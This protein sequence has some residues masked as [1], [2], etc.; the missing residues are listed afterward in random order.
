MNPTF[1]ITISGSVQGVGFRPFIYNLAISYNL[2]GYVSNNESGVI[3]VVQ[4]KAATV[5]EFYKELKKRHPKNA[6]INHIEIVEILSDQTF[7]TFSIKPTEKNIA[8]NALLTP[9]FAICKNCQSEV[10]DPENRRYSYPFISCTSCGPR[11]AIAKKFPFERENTSLN[12]FKM[13]ETC[14]EEYNNP[15]DIRFHSQTNSCPECGIKISFTDNEGNSIS[16]TNQEIFEALCKKLMEGKIVAVKNTSGYLLLCDAT[17]PKAV[18]EL[19][20]RK[21]R[22]TKPF[23]V[24]FKNI[25]QIENYLYCHK[26]EKKE[27]TSCQAPIVILSLKK[28][29]DLAAEEINPNIKTIGAMV[30]NSGILHLISNQ[31][32]KPLVATSG[33]FH[34]A[35][36]CT[37]QSEVLKSLHT[38]ADFYLHHNLEIQHSQD[39]SVLRFSKKHKQ[40]IILRRARGFAPNLDLSF[41]SHAS[42]KLLCLGADLKNTVTI[43]PNEQ[44]YV[45][46]YI[47][48]LANY[49]TYN[50]FEKKIN[51]SLNFFNFSPTK[52]IYDQHPNYEANHK[53][54]DFTANNNAIE[55]ITIQHHEAHF[56]AILS[57]KNL[58]EKSKTLGVVW[59]GAG[60]GSNIEIFG[61]EFFEYSKRQIKRIGHLEYFP[62]I[63]GDQMSKNPKISAFSISRNSHHF[64]H[65]FNK[66]EIKI[67]SQHI[68]NSLIKTTSMGRLFDATAFA[69]G[70]KTP[71]LF[72]G[73]A[74]MYLENLAQKAY[75][76]SNIKLKDYLQEE[77]ITTVIPSKKLVL[78]LAKA[79]KNNTNP[80]SVALNFHYTLVKCIEKIATFSKSKHI[81]FSGGVFQNTVL[82]DLIIDLLKPKFKLHFHEMLSPNDEN[83]S[84]GQLNHYLHLKR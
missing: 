13:C 36:I 35:A 23:A 76:K 17:N 71:I 41:S 43:T 6:K 40:K 22:F 58:W 75:N 7:D 21:K 10:L 74:G 56:A 84:F 59:D 61:G 30:P 3:I 18:Q 33:N 11:Y 60:F 1:Q 49:D 57:E 8:I 25:K 31:F 51:T 67:Y 70:F 50:R 32:Q 77:K 42:E 44:V 46:E 26:T 27:I 19:R 16:G 12:E 20:N 5:T 55:T 54:S 79:A 80:E 68:E 69:L 9:D 82:I 38:V 14:L 15:K 45:S 81:A 37:H 78:H 62:W 24:L 73:E 52:I 63:L 2:K 47:G 39:D 4:K 28:Q 65:L 29:A 48:D 83:I 66:N 53:V 64:Q 72:E 34:G